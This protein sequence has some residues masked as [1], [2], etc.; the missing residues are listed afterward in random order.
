[1]SLTAKD[2]Y[3]DL[4]EKQQSVVDALVE[5]PM[6]QNQEIAE[7]AD[8]SRSTVR[9]VKD[10][11]SH[12]I[13]AKLNEVGRYEGEERAEGD[14]FGGQLG[15]GDGGFQAIADRPVKGPAPGNG[16]RDADASVLNVDLHEGDIRQMLS[17]G[18]ISERLRAELV[19]AL[20]TEAFEK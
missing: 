8:V 16:E 14:P 3:A 7:L 9:N 10:N 12:I 19:E 2:S 17:T 15:G 13:E 6:A 1:M 4:T 11:Y 18:Q 5:N 20:I